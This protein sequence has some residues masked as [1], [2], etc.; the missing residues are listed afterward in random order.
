MDEHPVWCL[1]CGRRM[2]EA[3]YLE[4]LK[5]FD[6]EILAVRCPGCDR[7]ES[8]VATCRQCGGTEMAGVV[9][10]AGKCSV[11]E[12]VKLLAPSRRATF[13]VCHRQSPQSSPE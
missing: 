12:A 3:V 2:R 11:R 7:K 4:L 1:S 5:F 9:V 8:L 13:R 10:A 6:H